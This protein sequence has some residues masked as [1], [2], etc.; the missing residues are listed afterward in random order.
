MY[1]EKQR[2]QGGRENDLF[3]SNVDQNETPSD[4]TFLTKRLRSHS[5]Q[6]YPI[7][8]IFSSHAHAI[9]IDDSLARI[10]FSGGFVEQSWMEILPVRYQQAGIH[11][12]LEVPGYFLAR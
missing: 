11:L 10:Y 9:V 2:A 4:V 8:C 3:V 5:L 7:G 1:S 12:G 6:P